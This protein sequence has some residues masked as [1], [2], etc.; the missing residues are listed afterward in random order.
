MYYFFQPCTLCTAF[1]GFPILPVS[2]LYPRIPQAKLTV[3]SPLRRL[4]VYFQTYNPAYHKQSLCCL[5][6]YM[7]NRRCICTACL[8]S[9]SKVLLCRPVLIFIPGCTNICLC[10]LKLLLPF[11]NPQFLPHKSFL[12][13]HLWYK[14]QPA[15][16]HLHPNAVFLQ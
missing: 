3:L 15:H 2:F 1:P 4:E 10:K 8:N 16:T 11:L 7:K 5:S 12:S 14:L 6:Q 13:A 9:V